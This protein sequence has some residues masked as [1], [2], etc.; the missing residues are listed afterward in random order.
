[1]NDL[2]IEYWNVL[3]K[4]FSIQLIV[5]RFRASI[6]FYVAESFQKSL[7]HCITFQCNSVSLALH[8]LCFSYRPILSHIWI[9]LIGSGNYN[10]NN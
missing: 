10:R 3:Q 6:F 7:R 5:L 9:R 4:C 1:M 2:M 8:C